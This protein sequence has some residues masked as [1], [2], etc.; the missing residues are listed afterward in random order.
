MINVLKR[1]KL[2]G[3]LAKLQNNYSQRFSQPSLSTINTTA[4][5]YSRPTANLLF[6]KYFRKIQK[7]NNPRFLSFIIIGLIIVIIAYFGI[8]NLIKPKSNTVAGIQDNKI[9]IQKAKSTYLLNREFLFPL[10]DA[11]GKEISKLKYIIQTAELRDEIIIKGQKATTVRGRT[12]L[13]LNLKITND[14]NKSIQINA[15]DYIRLIVDNSSEKLAPDIHNDPVEI[16]AISTKLT[17]LGFPINDTDINLTLRVGEI[18]GKKEL[19]KL[20]LK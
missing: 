1:F 20:N 11:T 2:A 7:Y 19:I 13:I 3:I 17:R 8:T 5:D 4:N 6:N 15:R 12:F 9:N 16:Q 10:K 14:Y 18:D